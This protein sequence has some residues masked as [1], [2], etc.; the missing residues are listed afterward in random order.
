MGVAISPYEFPKK[1]EKI[2]M[3]QGKNW[4]QGRK[5]REKQ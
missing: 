5:K 2:V 1:E 4:R 3:M